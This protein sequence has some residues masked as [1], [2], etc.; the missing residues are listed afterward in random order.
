[1]TDSPADASARDKALDPRQSFIVDA[2]AGSG[3][4]TL[5]TQRFLRLLSITEQPESIVAITFTRKAAEEMRGRILDALRLAGDAPQ[6]LDPA[7]RRWAIAALETS[8]TKNWRLLDNPRRLRIQTIDS[9]C[10]TLAR[11]G[12]LL[13]GYT[14]GAEV[15]E[16][17]TQLYQLAAH[18]T[19]G[20]LAEPGTWSNAVRVL[21]R[22]LDN[23]WQRLEGLLVEMLARRDQWLRVVVQDP[24]RRVFESALESAVTDEL[25]ALNRILPGD[26]RSDLLRLC[27]LVGAN[28]VH[29]APDNS[30]CIL[31]GLATLPGA[32][33]D[34]LGIWQA[35]ARMFLTNEG[36]IRKKV[37]KTQ[38]FPPK[39][40]DALDN[41][42]L[43]FA[44]AEQLTAVPGLVIVMDTVRR[45]PSPS[46]SDTQWTSV[47]ALFR[48]LKLAAAE[49]KITFRRASVVDFSE[50]SHAALAALGG[51]QDPSELGLLLDYQIQ[52]LLI[53]EFQD[54]SITQY[55]LIER[56]LDGWTDGDGRTLFLVGD[57]MQSIYRFRQAE[58]GLFI[59]TR[60]TARLASVPLGVLQLTTNFRTQ[61]TLIDWINN[62][63][64]A[65]RDD[66]VCPFDQMP[67]L[68]AARAG[69]NPAPACV[70]GF[71]AEDSSAEADAV[72]AI[73]KQH[74]IENPTASIGILVRGR[75]HLGSISNA[76]SIAGISVNATE[77]ERLGDQSIVQDLLA[78]TRAL[79]HR[80]DRTAWLGVLRAPWCGLSLRALATLF[81]GDRNR[82]IWQQINDES[83]ISQL[84]SEEQKLLLNFRMNFEASL[85][86]AGR[87][88][89]APLVER[90]WLGLEGSV[91]YS[92]LE[93]IHA[94]R[95]LELLQMCERRETLVTASRLEEI[96]ERQYV[97]PPAQKESGVAIMTIHRA[98]GLEFDVVILPGLGRMARAEQHSLLAWRAHNNSSGR[99]LLFA[100][101]PQIGGG[102][103]P[104]HGFLH[105]AEKK[106]LA[107]ESYRL[108]YV[109]LTRARESLHLIGTIK[110]ARQDEPATPAARSF[111][112][113]LWGSVGHGSG[114]VAADSRTAPLLSA[115]LAVEQTVTRP[116]LDGPLTPRGLNF[117]SL[118]KGL[119]GDIEF[120]W[121]SPIAKHI[122]TVTH[123]ILQL[124][125]RDGGATYDATRI[126]DLSPAI[127]GRL[128]ALGVSKRELANARERIIAASIGAITSDRGRWILDRRHN[129]AES[130]Y[131]LTA[132]SNGRSSNIII[133]RTFIDASGMRWIIDFKTGS[134]SGGAVQAFL[135]SEV[136]RY[137]AQLERYARFIALRENNPITLG[138]FFP[139]L[140]EWREW[141]FAIDN[142]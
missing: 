84:G 109:A 81:E 88:A 57:P 3:K 102:D 119:P 100:P 58:V 113:M 8:Q 108:L 47:Q 7:T 18:A 106:D 51:S 15:R 78:L 83:C 111:L 54:T 12:P 36:K 48:V 115:P 75:S 95:Y 126:S 13:S 39:G 26:L 38:G 25:I 69:T 103:D 131:S 123:T 14:G 89:I 1:M 116:V 23:D 107:D 94:H 10:A 20:V 117:T 135:D 141:R 91:A 46:Y 127:D 72:V 21:L 142:S 93:Q 138:L 99:R 4:T 130:E 68:V 34:D 60:S 92:K 90:A 30:G 32:S 64:A 104:I 44:L 87:E 42:A 27:R 132:V 56:L 79:L 41:K 122:G 125:C 136:E 101:I 19:I 137:R 112:R 71:I 80:G 74:Q 62:T 17:A 35:I 52:H 76:L 121:A 2:P 40:Q 70:H 31:D 77:I 120:A 97:A 134:H 59:D 110:K 86:C 33:C 28:L 37:T 118:Q 9:L 65:M 22:H 73:V 85:Q 45:T 133:D 82:T 43:F 139:L 67:R 98:K 124:I 63:I 105:E 24:D 129:M 96:L 29:E 66:P 114:F 49:L 6:S 16:N 61:A 53:D 55:E 140:G 128:R 50:V 5:L 11:R